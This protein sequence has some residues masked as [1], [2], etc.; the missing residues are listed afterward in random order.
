[1]TF[2]PL[3]LLQFLIHGKSLVIAQPL[4]ALFFLILFI[5]TEFSPLDLFYKMLS[6]T[7]F[8]WGML[9]GINQMRMLQYCMK[10]ILSPSIYIT[11]TSPVFFAVLDHIIYAIVRRPFRVNLTRIGGPW[12]VIRVSVVLSIYL[13]VSIG[14]KFDY[15]L[16]GR[17]LEEIGL[18]FA[19]IQGL[20]NAVWV[21]GTDLPD[22]Y[23]DE[24]DKRRKKLE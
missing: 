4:S 16:G 12:F 15:L 22:Y 3:E 2:V 7:A 1:M 6:Y 13:F 14:H 19:L 24:D 5:L 20:M 17:S 8:I 9:Q 11:V 21:F 23:L 18:F 10:E